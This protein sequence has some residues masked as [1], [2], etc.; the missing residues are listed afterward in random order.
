MTVNNKLFST[1]NRHLRRLQYCRKNEQHLPLISLFILVVSLANLS[2]AFASSTSYVLVNGSF[3]NSAYMPG[4]TNTLDPSVD[5]WSGSGNFQVMANGLNYEDAH[6]GQKSLVFNAGELTPSGSIEQTVGVL[7]SET[8]FLSFWLMHHGADSNTRPGTVGIKAEVLQNGVVIAESSIYLDTAAGYN[9][10]QWYPFSLQARSA[11]SNMTVRFTDISTSGALRKDIG[12]DNVSLALLDT[13]GDG[14]S[15]YREGKDGTD[16]NDPESFNSLSKGL[17]AY[18]PFDNGLLDESGNG[19]HLEDATSGVQIVDGPFG[20]GS[21]SLKLTSQDDG[22]TSAKNTGVTGNQNHTISMWIYLEEIPAWAYTDYAGSLLTIGTPTSDQ[23]G[24]ESRILVDNQ[25]EPSESRIYAHGAF[26]D[27]EKKGLGDTFVGSWKHIVFSYNGNITT[28]SLYLDGSKVDASAPPGYDN[29]RNMGD[30]PIYVGSTPL[31]GGQSKGSVGQLANIR[32]YNRALPESEVHS[33]YALEAAGRDSDAD[34]FNDSIET[35]YNTDPNN[36]SDTPNNSRPTGAVSQWFDQGE[37]QSPV[38]NDLTETIQIAAGYAGYAL[39][40]DGTV[41]AWGEIWSG[42]GSENIP[43]YVP[44]GLSS[45]VQIDAGLNYALALRGHGSLETWGNFWDGNGHQPAFVPEGL[46]GVVQISAGISHAAALKADG[47]IAV[48]GTN[49]WGQTDVPAG[50]SD[51]VQV[52]AGGYH[53]MALKRDGTVVVWGGIHSQVRDIPAGLSDVVKIAAG[54]HVCVALKRDGTVVAWGSDNLGGIDV[55]VG[56][57]DVVAISASP[58]VA[59]I[60]LKQDGTAVSWGDK[61]NLPVVSGPILAADA[62]WGRNIVLFAAPTDSDNDGIPDNY[63]TNTGTWVSSTDTGT[64]PNNPDTD[65]DGLLDGVETNTGMYVS[66]DDTGTNPNLADS[67]GDGYNDKVESDAGTDPNDGSSTPM[68]TVQGGT[69]PQSSGL[70][71][72]TVSSFI[73]GKYEVTWREWQEVRSWGI[74][75]G[76]TDLAVGAGSSPRD[77]VRLVNQFDMVKWCN[78]RSEMEGLT[79]VYLVNGQT[80]RVGMPYYSNIFSVNRF[81]NGYRLPTEAEWEWAARGG[82]NSQD[83][84]YSGS[85]DPDLVAWHRGNSSSAPVDLSEGRGSWPVGSKLPNELGLHD[86][87]GNVWEIVS[88]GGGWTFSRDERGGG[89]NHDALLSALDF[90]EMV[91]GLNVDQGNVDSGFRLARSLDLLPPDADNDGVNDYRENADG[92]NPNDANSFNPLSKGLVA[93][94]RLNGDSADESGYG[95]HAVNLGAEATA[96]RF[97]T[98]SSAFSFDGVGDYMDAPPL[99]SDYQRNFTFSGW[100]RTTHVSS[101]RLDAAVSALCKTRDAG[102]FGGPAIDFREGKAVFTFNNNRVYG[103]LIPFEEW[104]YATPDLL[105][106]GN[107]RHYI[108]SIDANGLITAFINGQQVASHQI[109]TFLEVAGASPFQIGRAGGAHEAGRYFPGQIDEVR[110][111]NRGLTAEEATMLYSESVCGLDSDADGVTDYRERRDGTNPYDVASFEPLSVALLANY[112]FDGSWKDESGYCRDVLAP[113]TTFEPGLLGSSLGLAE[114]NSQASYWND[115]NNT[116]SLGRINNFTFSVWMKAST[117]EQPDGQA[118]YLVSAPNNAAYL[119]IANGAEGSRVLG[120]GYEWPSIPGYGYQTPGTNV[121]RTGVWQHVVGVQEAEVT[122]IYVNGTLVGSTDTGELVPFDP[123]NFTLGNLFNS[124]TFQGQLDEVRIYGRSL[125]PAEVGA[126]YALEIGDLDSDNDGLDDVHET[127]TGTFVSATDAGTDPYNPD[128]S[129]D[130]ILDGEAVLW[131]F[132]PLTDHS[133]VLA[134]LRHATGVQS[135]RFGLFTEGSIMDIN[136]GGVMIQKSGSQASVRFKVQS[137]M[138]L[139]DAIWSD[140]GTYLLPPIDMPGSKGFL[141]IRAEQ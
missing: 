42:S 131:N 30:G 134:F 16:P 95:N 140:R 90:R 53:T 135:G 119:R 24:K 28:S 88:L 21:K 18:Y 138:D 37:D 116:E 105:A 133:Q 36:A 45:V 65:G 110:I 3:E 41:A 46:S 120:L 48:W 11:T 39:K 25:Q 12:L 2:S 4:N 86:M 114:G 137:K 129:G 100:I 27:L 92:T 67:D 31:A 23:V 107:W 47:T 77:P 83:F 79:P 75:N 85:N 56:L 60:A 97:G 70:A 98:N 132:N 17:V 13:D 89:W 104:E 68:V 59:T 6:Q 127:N 62:G 102:D 115:P 22:A 20:A 121:L 19:N 71:G 103:D 125:S 58:H 80:Y 126:L 63:E 108:M 74:S 43:A 1:I 122:R 136:L 8:Y 96:D 81:A 29:I 141:R 106:D 50:L 87:S 64:D 51:V 26:S 35:H 124:N 5:G 128:T 99:I 33:L 82:V 130:G 78:A 15:D 109:A 14:V 73:I 76:Y 7:P 40:A 44:E 9:I 38:P 72:T 101:D 118:Y 69:L 84:I 139:R 52:E 94:Y 32:V 111:Y 93:Y 10:G 54:G 61:N 123:E 117:L 112:P 57:T 49:N 66:Q 34:G 55:P 113:Y 91:I